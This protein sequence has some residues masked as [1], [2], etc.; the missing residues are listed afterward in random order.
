MEAFKLI[1][2]SLEHRQQQHVIKYLQEE[3]RV[4]KEQQGSRQPKFDRVF[5]L[6]VQP[7]RRVPKIGRARSQPT[8]TALSSYPLSCLPLCFVASRRSWHRA[9]KKCKGRDSRL[10]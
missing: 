1:V 3:V 5:L 2:V 10:L 6:A 4:L 9:Q 7:T 8:F